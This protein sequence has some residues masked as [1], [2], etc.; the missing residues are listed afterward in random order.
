MRDQDQTKCAIRSIDSEEKFL[1]PFGSGQYAEIYYADGWNGS[2]FS[3]AWDTSSGEAFPIILPEEIWTKYALE[4]GELMGV[5]SK[6]SFRMC[7]VAGYYTGDIG[8]ASSGSRRSA[9]NE[10]RPILMPT[11]ALRTM[12]RR[13][14]YSKAVFT[15]DPAQTRN[16]SELQAAID[17]LANAPRIGGVPVRIIL[18]DEELRMAVKPLEASI[19][20][21]EILYPVTL[22]L[23]L[24]AAAGVTALLI[25]LSAREA[26]IMR[27]QGTTKRRSRV[28]LA[29]QTAVTSLAGLLLG[30]GG[31]LAY[32]GRTRPEL[33]AGL[34]GA[35]VL[36]AMLY[37]L[38][39]IAGAA[40]SAAAVT[41]RNPLELLQV[42]E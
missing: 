18:W 30:L 20:L 39:A 34:V 41:G 32:A 22:A 5:A 37:L 40:A 25:M 16:I 19:R 21:M 9:Y 13:M 12:V 27:V 1:S 36:C 29:L 28:M 8:G 26:A 33:L 4:G 38:A 15:V 35:S 11:S 3:T 17:E 7:A 23:S 42:K 31:A 6:G 10:S 2:L 14:L 24:L